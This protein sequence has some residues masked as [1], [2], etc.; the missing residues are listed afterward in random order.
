MMAESGEKQARKNAGSA[1]IST[2]QQERQGQISLRQNNNQQH[3]SAFNN[4]REEERNGNNPWVRVTDNCDL[5]AQG[6]TVGGKD[7]SRMKQ[8]MLNRKADL[9][10]GGE[11]QMGSFNTNK[12]GL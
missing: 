4:K 2:W 3:E 9:A 7:K 1:A 5:T 10:A 11:V 12:D 8:A 6:L